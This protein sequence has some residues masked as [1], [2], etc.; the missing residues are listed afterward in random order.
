MTINNRGSVFRRGSN[1][2]M[3]L[4]KL[5]WQKLDCETRFCCFLRCGW[6]LVRWSGTF[7]IFS[8]QIIA[9]NTEQQ[10]L[11]INISLQS[12]NQPEAQQLSLEIWWKKKSMLC[13]RWHDKFFF[14]LSIWKQ[15]CRTWLTLCP[16]VILS[17]RRLK[18]L[19]EGC[20]VWSSSAPNLGKS[21][22]HAPMTAGFSSLN[23]MGESFLS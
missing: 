22:K 8:G 21:P 19:G 7:L 9:P 11:S 23:E 5:Q 10:N 13:M 6:S 4:I 3:Y 1:I 15:S 12:V 18:S 14:I 2:T 20:K 16:H 17:V